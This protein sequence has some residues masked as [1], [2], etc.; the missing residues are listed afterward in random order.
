MI[1]DVEAN[2]LLLGDSSH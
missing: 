1:G 2:N